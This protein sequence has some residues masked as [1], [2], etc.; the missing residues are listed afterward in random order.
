MQLLE[1]YIF[2]DVENSNKNVFISFHSSKMIVENYFF[3]FIQA[4]APVASLFV[5]LQNNVTKVNNGKSVF[6]E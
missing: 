5:T 3:Y 1:I 2:S 4:T 6:I